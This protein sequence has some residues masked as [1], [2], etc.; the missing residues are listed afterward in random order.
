[1]EVGR[2]AIAGGNE[3]DEGEGYVE[4]L[5]GADAEALDGSFVEDAAKEIEECDARRE[6]AAVR[7][8]IDA[9]E[10]DFAIAGSASC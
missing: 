6:I 3:I 7:A 8:E 4:R 1:M 10:N 9:A 5:D 2:E